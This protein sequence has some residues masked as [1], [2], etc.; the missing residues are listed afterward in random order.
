M[1][2]V[3]DKGV[4]ERWVPAAVRVSPWKACSLP[5]GFALGLLAFGLLPSVRANPRLWWSFAGA[6][7]ALLVWSALLL[8]AATATLRTFTLELVLRKQ[9]YVQACAHTAIFLYWG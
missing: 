5:A 7:A 6:S 1:V 4:T 9:H 2:S 3:A 8:R